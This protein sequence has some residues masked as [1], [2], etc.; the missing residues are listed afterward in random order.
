MHLISRDVGDG[1]ALVERDLPQTAS[2]GGGPIP[3]QIEK[4]GAP[5]DFSAISPRDTL[6][7]VEGCSQ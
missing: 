1:V 4:P 2:L 6:M 5:S 3:M 7:L